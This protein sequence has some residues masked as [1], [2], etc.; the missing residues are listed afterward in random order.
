MTGDKEFFYL[1]GFQ[2][3]GTT[4]L[5]HLL[6]KH[7]EVVCAEEPEFSKR[8]VLGQ[9]GK[10][11]DLDNDS[12]GKVLRYYDV[13]HA[14]YSGLVDQYSRGDMDSGDFLENSYRLF[15]RK[16]ARSTGVKEVCDLSVYRYNYIRKLISY[17]KGNVRFIFIERDIKGVVNSF[18]KLGFF[19]PRKQRINF[20]NLKK[21]AG[22]YLKCLN[23][24]K[25][26][27]PEG[28][29]HYLTY[30]RLLENP[31]SE[32]EKIFGFLRVSSSDKIMQEII[33]TPSRGIR[34]AYNGIIRENRD[35]WLKGL[36]EKEIRWLD[37]YFE[38]KTY[39]KRFRHMRE[40][41]N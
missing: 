7:P 15:N 26:N 2:R 30:E 3:S 16:N 40:E 37:R 18:V 29:T 1:T 20:F 34:L 27:L 39:R 21:F 24:I 31:K 12:T 14:D 38:K 32:L 6:D 23:Y 33:N 10:L 41:C 17:H 13:D 5:C 4:L 25:K 36:D 8:I 28:N 22:G 19:P 35:R 9:E 11:K